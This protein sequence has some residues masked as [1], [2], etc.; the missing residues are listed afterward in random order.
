MKLQRPCVWTT[1]Y[2]GRHISIP[3]CV[4]A[5]DCSRCH[6]LCVRQ[7]VADEDAQTSMLIEQGYAVIYGR[8]EDGRPVCE[9]CL[10]TNGVAK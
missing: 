9:L 2:L 4:Q 5:C 7:A 8:H 1:D 6:R 3:P 10:K